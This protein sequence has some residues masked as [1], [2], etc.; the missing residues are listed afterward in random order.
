MFIIDLSRNIWPKMSLKRV[1]GGFIFGP[2]L[3]KM[4]VIE[5][6]YF[7]VTGSSNRSENSESDS[8]GTYLLLTCQG[9]YG[10]K[11]IFFEL[12]SFKVQNRSNV[13][14]DNWVKL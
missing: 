7:W 10:L 8:E 14:Y 9:T 1:I 12:F 2:R 13:N 3:P 11:R 6:I 4:A 5:N